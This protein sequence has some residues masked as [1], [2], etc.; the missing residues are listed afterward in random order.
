MNHLLKPFL[1]ALFCLTSLNVS[2]IEISF[3]ADTNLPIVYLSLA[4]KGGGTTDP[5]QLS[6]LT[7]F[8]G[9]MLLRGTHQRNKAQLGNALDELGARLE[10]E[11]KAE[12][13]ILRGAVLSQN[14]DHFLKILTEVITQPSFSSREISKLRR[15]TLSDILEQQSEDSQ[16]SARLIRK[17]L[18]GTHPYSGLAVGTSAGVRKITRTDVVRH[19][20]KLFTDH[21]MIVAGTGDS[22][23]Q[24][25][26]RWAFDLARRRSGSA[27][28][29]ALSSPESSDTRKIVWIEKPNRTQ[30]WIRGALTGVTYLDADYFSLYVGNHTFGGD[31]TYAWLNQE[32]RVKTGWS[33]G[34]YSYFLMGSVPHSWQFYFYPAT[35]DAIPALQKA[36]D[37]IEKLHKD[38]VT[39]SQFISAKQSLLNS[40]SF[41]YNTPEKRVENTIEEKTLG[42]PNGFFRTFRDR[43]DDVTF[44]ET[45]AALKKYIRPKAITWTVLGTGPE[46]KKSVIESFLPNGTQFVSTSYRDE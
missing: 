39:E 26:E 35:K 40:S 3:E 1:L 20:Q 6:G 27:M 15:E 5:A 9:E 43:I 21:R 10:I 38:G 8:T 4:I 18:F 24:T 25:I 36:R 16:I 7:Q 12:A 30:V 44:S 2:A 34:S 28:I 32:I 33:Y 29:P 14:L 13:L 46:L 11:T 31:L 22:R 19:Y 42:L 23:I 45:N 37:L 41:M 17:Y